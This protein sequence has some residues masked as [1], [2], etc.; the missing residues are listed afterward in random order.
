M[1]LFRSFEERQKEAGEDAA[2]K[3]EEKGREIKTNPDVIE[4]PGCCGFGSIL[5]NYWNY[6]RIFPVTNHIIP[7]CI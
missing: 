4:S 5:F 6:S 2:M 1:V 7:F 3:R